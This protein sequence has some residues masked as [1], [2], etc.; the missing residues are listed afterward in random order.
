MKEE[1][2]GTEE[3]LACWRGNKK[4]EARGNISQYDSHQIFIIAAPRERKRG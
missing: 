4:I 3:K 1:K 2:A